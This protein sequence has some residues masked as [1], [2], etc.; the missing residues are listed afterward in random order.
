MSGGGKPAKTRKPPAKPAKKKPEPEGKPKAPSS[1]GLLQHVRLFD[2]KQWQSAP[3]YRQ[4]M[5][6]KHSDPR[7]GQ[8]WQ[9]MELSGE[10]GARAAGKDTIT[11]LVAW[12]LFVIEGEAR[13]ALMDRFKTLKVRKEYEGCDMLMIIG[14][15]WM[16]VAMVAKEA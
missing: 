15:A 9:A 13:S 8:R 3:R 2:A 4:N 7:I 11:Q 1:K 12:G 16:D 5:L 14:H 6:H 10:S